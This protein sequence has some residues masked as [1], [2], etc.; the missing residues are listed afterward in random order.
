MVLVFT[1]QITTAQVTNGDFGSATGWMLDGNVEYATVG[2]GGTVALFQEPGEGT[3]AGKGSRARIF[4]SNLDFTGKPSIIFRYRL[5]VGTGT[6]DA[7]VPPDSFTAALYDMTAQARLAPVLST[8]VPDFSNGF[9]YSDSD[10]A[11]E[12]DSSIVSVTGPDGSGMKTVTL[13]LSTLTL[14]TTARL[15][16]GFASADNGVTSAVFLDDVE[17]DCTSSTVYCCSSGIPPVATTIDDGKPCTLDTCQPN[18]TVTHDLFDCCGACDGDRATDTAIMVMIDVSATMPQLELQ[19]SK[20]AV[21]ELLNR[22]RGE[23]NPPR[24]GLARFYEPVDHLVDL[25]TNYDAVELALGS[26]TTQSSVS[27]MKNA[28]EHATTELSDASLAGFQKYMVLITDGWT[29][30]PRPNAGQPIDT[31]LSGCCQVPPTS[32]NPNAD[33]ICG[34]SPARDAAKT[35]ADAAEAS[36]IQIYVA[37]FVGRIETPSVRDACF[38][39]SWRADAIAWMESDIATTPEHI[40]KN[41]DV[42]N[43]L[44]DCAMTSMVELINCDDLDNCTTDSCI[45]GMC[46]HTPIAGCTP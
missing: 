21:V 31:C 15:E 40:F 45:Q 33:C 30:L 6:R 27:N 17:S 29:A 28:I 19:S 14:P 9:Y 26:I 35:A 1:S 12:F 20:D 2:A 46:T 34:C 36:G 7:A 41:T 5:S 4:Q 38:D 24:I 22:F 25:T 23:P 13:D 10:G 11:E 44:V 39:A 8:D 3:V 37:H 16:F 32:C 42:A 18:G 43:I